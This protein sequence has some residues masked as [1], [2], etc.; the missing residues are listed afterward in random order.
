MKKKIKYTSELPRLL[1]TFFISHTDTAGAPSF[2]KFAR[3]IGATS[4]DIE[5]FRKHSEFERAYRE[6][7]EIRRDYLIDS[8]LTRRYDPSF[9]KFLLT[10][11]FG[12]G[13][14]DKEKDDTGLTVT[15]EVLS[16]GKNES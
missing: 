9:T 5:S 15:L 8:A 6:C 16:D 13:D 10:E 3:S 2:H 7:S 4:S 11:E 1:Y 14:K 12:M